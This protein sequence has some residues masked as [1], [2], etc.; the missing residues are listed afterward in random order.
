MNLYTVTTVDGAVTV[1]GDAIRI[2]RR[3]RLHV[4]QV[5]SDAHVFASDVWRSC[6]KAESSYVPP[7]VRRPRPSK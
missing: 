2:D 6:V 3:G 5:D 4:L 1:Q 7:P